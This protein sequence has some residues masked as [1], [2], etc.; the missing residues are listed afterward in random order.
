MSSF[1]TSALVSVNFEDYPYSCE[2]E[3]KF[4]SDVLARYAIDDLPDSF[5][6]STR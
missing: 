5:V 1:N 3:L 2:D 4:G 6:Y